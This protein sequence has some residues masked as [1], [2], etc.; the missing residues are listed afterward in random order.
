MNTDLM[1]TTR[2][3]SRTTWQAFADERACCI[4]H[5]TPRTPVVFKVINL[6]YI[7][8]IAVLIMAVSLWGSP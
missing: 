5:C 1:D 4:E 8:A 3:Y 6:A 7:A 2:S